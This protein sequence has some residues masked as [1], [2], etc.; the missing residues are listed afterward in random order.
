MSKKANFFPTLV[1]LFSI[2]PITSWLLLHFLCFGHQEDHLI[3]VYILNVNCSKYDYRNSSSVERGSEEGREGG[4]RK[5]EGEEE[6]ESAREKRTL[7]K[8][9]DGSR[10]LEFENG[11]RKLSVNLAPAARKE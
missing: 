9:L 6:E 7:R 11:K 4:R 2:K 10:S 5:E 3:Y 8:T 1:S